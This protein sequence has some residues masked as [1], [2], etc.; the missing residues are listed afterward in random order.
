[1]KLLLG[2]CL[3]RQWPTQRAEKREETTE[4]RASK[5]TQSHCACSTNRTPPPPPAPRPAT[6]GMLRGLGSRATLAAA[7]RAGSS[8]KRRREDGYL[9]T[10][11]AAL[12]GWLSGWV[13]RREESSLCSPGAGASPGSLCSSA[14]AR[15]R[16]GQPRHRSQ[17]GAGARV[18]CGL[19]K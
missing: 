16:L 4:E 18:S 6:S 17:H 3:H 14:W 7:L 5:A 11:S 10:E 13:F 12:G 19:R 9:P 15:L 2:V 1:M 8:P